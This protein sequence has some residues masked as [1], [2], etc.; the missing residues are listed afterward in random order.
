VP[1]ES[2]VGCF[3]GNTLD[4]AFLDT[5]KSS[6]ETAWFAKIHFKLDTGAEVTA[7]SQQAYQ[8]VGEPQLQPS[9]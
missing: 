9:D 7:I 1:H 2:S 6:S 4:T 3:W 5:V 8:Q